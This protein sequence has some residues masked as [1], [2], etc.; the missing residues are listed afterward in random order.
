VLGFVVCPTFTNKSVV[1][2][3]AGI[4]SGIEIPH[5]KDKKNEKKI[6]LEGVDDLLVKWNRKPPKL[7]E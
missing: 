3:V 5:K 7:L 4:G 6:W 2:E 1:L